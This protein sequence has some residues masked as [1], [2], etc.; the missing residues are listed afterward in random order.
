MEAVCQELILCYTA[1]FITLVSFLIQSKFEK[2]AILLY[3]KRGN[4]ILYRYVF[5]FSLKSSVLSYHVAYYPK[6]IEKYSQKNWPAMLGHP[7]GR[8]RAT[9]IFWQ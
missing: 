8:G 7:E 9:P 5:I 1:I 6:K 4:N 2:N 3:I